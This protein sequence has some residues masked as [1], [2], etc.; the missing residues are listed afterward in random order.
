MPWLH[1][2]YIYCN[3][4]GAALKSVRKLHLIQNAAAK[5][6]TGVSDRDHITPILAHLHWLPAW[7]MS[8]VV[9]PTQGISQVGFHGPG[10]SWI[11]LSC[12]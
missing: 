6:L 11:C 7:G 8:Q 3:I 12:Y 4:H 9:Q 1:L 10:L 2:G 5:M